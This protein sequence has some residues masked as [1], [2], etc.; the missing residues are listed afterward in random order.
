MNKTSVLI[1]GAGPAGL[2]A[3]ITL[4]HQQPETEIC[5]IDK[6]SE[7]GNHNLSGATVETDAL[8]ML[9]APINPNWRQSPQAQ[10][11]LGYKV[12]KDNTMFFAGDKFAFNIA[13]S[14]KIAEKLNLNFAQMSHEGNYILSI[15]RLV[16]WLCR[17][18]K[19]MG[20][21]VIHGF[22]AE[23]IIY[24]SAQNI[25]TGI[26]LVEQGLDKGGKKQPNYI[27]GETI[28]ADVIVLAEGCDGLVTE[29]FIE[30][31]GLARRANQLY[32]VGVKEIIK[33]SDEQF[34]KFTTGRVVH[35][36]GYPLWTPVLGPGMFGGGVMHP[37]SENHIAVGMIVGL[38]WKYCDFNPQDA[39]TNFKNHRFVKKFI[40]GGTVV[41][42]GAKMIPEGGFYSLPRTPQTSAVGKSNVLILG[43]AAGFVNMLKI[44]GL[45]NAIKSGIAA[46]RAIAGCTSNLNAAASKY[47]ELLNMLGVMEELKQASRFRQNVA[48]L[49]PLFGIPISVF[50]QKVPMFKVKK[51]YEVMTGRK[52]KYKP[53]KNYDKTTFAALA[54]T[55]HREEQP[56][57][58]TI[59]NGN[60]CAQKCKSKFDSPCI[61]FCPAGVYET[62]G[63][64]VKAANPSNCLHCKTCQR[65]CP[66]DNI[67]W[68]APEGGGGPRYKNT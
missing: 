52:Y 68:T 28:C 3:A 63:G 36:M 32:S 65:K 53:E 66:L 17:V 22:A 64:Q 34:K 56:S 46:G 50:G 33:V 9:F 49:G 40:E 54:A 16:K 48:K 30:K 20:V 27:A 7:G 10:E 35:A 43:D 31:A 39:L 41:E 14:I 25:A 6:A 44:K 26:K 4:K 15:S 51:D 19:D 23:D 38:D 13:F 29:K 21:E 59:V 60:T 18:A 62:V 58:L 8:A 47:T 42:A 24:D 67:R 2:A 11:I 5:V 1:V 37:V 45:H 57:H 12:T 61:T 55:E